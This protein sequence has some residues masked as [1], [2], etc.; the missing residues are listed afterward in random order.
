MTPLTVN[1][2]PLAAAV[3]VFCATLIR[4]LAV[5]AKLSSPVCGRCGYA[6][7]RHHMGEPVCRCG[8]A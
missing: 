1:S 6:L 2:L 5:Q 4:G 7:E 8:L 3:L